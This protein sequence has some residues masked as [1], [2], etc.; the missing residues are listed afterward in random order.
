MKLYYDIFAEGESNEVLSDGFKI[1]LEFDGVMGKVQSSL[2]AVGDDN[3]DV[4]C[5]NEFG[6]A[7]KE[8][9]Q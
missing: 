6:G 5:G 7:G 4:G 8:E 9:E 1:T 3:V 2:I